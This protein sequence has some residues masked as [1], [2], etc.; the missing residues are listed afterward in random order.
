[1]MTKNFGALTRAIAVPTATGLGLCLLVACTAPVD[2]PSSG[3]PVA[4]ESGEPVAPESGETSASTAPGA[5]AETAEAVARASAEAETTKEPEAAGDPLAS[6]S[7]EARAL[8]AND[9]TPALGSAGVQALGNIDGRCA[10]FYRDINYGRYIGSLCVG[11]G[12]DHLP[13]YNQWNDEI[14]SIVVG[15][16]INLYVCTELDCRVGGLGAGGVNDFGRRY[17]SGPNKVPNLLNVNLGGFW[18]LDYNDRISFVKVFP[19]I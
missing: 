13:S 6:V 16:G 15:G 5:P 9:A 10:Y 7:A 8:I 18:K 11:S 1:M 4:P 14:S 12:G 3:E 19:K 2:A 17:F